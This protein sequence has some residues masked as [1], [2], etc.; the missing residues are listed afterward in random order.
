MPFKVLEAPALQ[1]D[2]YLNLIDWSPQNYIAV[3]LATSVYL[4]N[5][6]NCESF[7]LC[8]LG[9]RNSA[10]SVG[11][12]DKHPLLAIGTH[13]GIVHVW[14]IEKIRKVRSFGGHS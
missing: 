14:D 7:R 13:S 11:F 6:K 8:D 3:G 2:F 4:W 9:I 1:D 5:P 10:T 12:C